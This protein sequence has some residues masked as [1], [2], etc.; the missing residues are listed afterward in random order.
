M[1][2]S[3]SDI[4]VFLRFL[5]VPV[6]TVVVFD[7]HTKSESFSVLSSVSHYLSCW[8]P[9]KVACWSVACWVV[10]LLWGAAPLLASLP[11]VTSSQGSRRRKH[12]STP[13]EQEERGGTHTTPLLPSSLPKPTSTTPQ[14]STP[15]HNSLLRQTRHHTTNN[16]NLLLISIIIIM[17]IHKKEDN[18]KHNYNC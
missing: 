10:I 6:F 8:C 3:C 13:K 15:R 7:K 4:F 12:L 1:F 5:S 2:L 14:H 16:N 11:F 17:M 9:C 18:Y